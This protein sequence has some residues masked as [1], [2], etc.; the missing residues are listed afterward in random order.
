MGR[1]LE[2]AADEAALLEA[3]AELQRRRPAD[4]PTTGIARFARRA[5]R[6]IAAASSALADGSWVPQPVAAVRM[7]KPT[8][9][10]RTLGIPAIIDRIVE[11]SILSVIDPVLDGLLSPWCFGYRRGLG[12]NDAIRAV[13]DARDDG[14]TAVLRVDIEDCFD[15]IL[16]SRLIGIL[17]T[18]LDDPDLI[19]VLSALIRRP[20]ASRRPTARGIHQGSPLSPL[21]AN[22][23]LDEFDR[24]MMAAGLVAIRYADDIAVPLS[25]GEDPDEVLALISESLGSLGMR[26]GEDKCAVSSFEDGVTFLG[27]IITAG[28]QVRPERHDRPTATTIF[29]TTDGAVLRSRGHRMRIDRDGEEPFS[30]GYDR[31]RQ[32]VIFGRA[33]LTTAFLQQVLRR[34]ID[35]TLLSSTGRYFGRVQGQMSASPF[36]RAAQYALFDD[37]DQ[38]LDIARRIISGKIT[39]QRSLLIRRQRSAGVGLMSRIERLAGLRSS[40]DG[41]TSMMQLSGIEG[42]ASREYFGGLAALVGN[43]FV[44]TNRRRR[45]PPDPVNA[46]LSFGYTLLTQEIIAAVETAGLD[47]FEGIVH[48][49]RVGRPSLALDLVEEFRAVIVDSTVLR[50]IAMRIITPEDFDYPEHPTPMCRLLPD[51]RRRFLAAYEQR[52]LT[53]MTH[54]GS[55]RRV[56]YRVATILQAQSLAGELLGHQA[57]YVPVVWK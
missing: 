9:G 29:V 17:T 53:L 6:E 4:E 51:A 38:R 15:R 44:F 34:E 8:G 36:L 49:R 23:Y 57:R 22:L 32:V 1:L 27:S 21:F 31:V 54:S 40:L 39:N 56:S 12:I 48:Q 26:L 43:G 25:S 30:I 3:W 7:P 20:V 16:R 42:A 45:P 33:H 50:L 52:M 41:A 35:V 24:T 28:S 19:A 5:A 11:R 10:F 55:G 37:D 14:A 47:P 18:H 2:R 46:M 13:I